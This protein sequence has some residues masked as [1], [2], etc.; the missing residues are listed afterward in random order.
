MLLLHLQKRKKAAPMSLRGRT[1]SAFYTHRTQTS[2]VLVKKSVSC[3]SAFSEVGSCRF[4]LK[5]FLYINLHPK[6]NLI[7]MCP[8]RNLHYIIMYINVSMIIFC[9]VNHCHPLEWEKFTVFSLNFQV[10]YV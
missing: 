6:K 7:K 5:L 2:R 1:P 10:K 3:L 9:L 4:L 8:L